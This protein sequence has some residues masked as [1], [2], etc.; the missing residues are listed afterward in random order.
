MVAAYL[1]V[2]LLLIIPVLASVIRAQAPLEADSTG[3]R[4]FVSVQH[5][6]TGHGVIL[7]VTGWE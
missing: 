4:F 5:N 7:E 2:N 1:L 3:T 6:M